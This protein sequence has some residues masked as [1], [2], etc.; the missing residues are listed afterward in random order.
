MRYYVKKNGKNEIAGPLTV[1]EILSRVKACRL[2]RWDKV[3]AENG[4]TPEQIAEQT[5][6]Q[7]GQVSDVI[8][9]AHKTQIVAPVSGFTFDDERRQVIAARRA[10]AN[11]MM[12]HGALWCIGGIVVTAVTFSMASANSPGGSFVIAWG[13]ILFGFIRFLNGLTSR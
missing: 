13:A 1:E 5:D 11:K 8:A 10:A 4:R 6:L 3:V 7:W 9:A 12:V 2:D